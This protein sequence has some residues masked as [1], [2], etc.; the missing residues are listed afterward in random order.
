ML[1]NILGTPPWVGT[2][3]SEEAWTWAD[4]MIMLIFG[5]LPW[6]VIRAAKNNTDQEYARNLI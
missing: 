6:Q 3:T 4:A 1:S 2:I 5:G